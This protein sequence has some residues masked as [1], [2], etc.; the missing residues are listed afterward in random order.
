MGGLS[1]SGGREGGVNI[2]FWQALLNLIFS[3]WHLVHSDII[4]PSSGYVY[5][6][7]LNFRWLN[8]KWY[9]IPY[10][11]TKY[12]QKKRNT[13]Y[14]QCSAGKWEGWEERAM[15]LLIPASRALCSNY[16]TQ[17]CTAPHAST[18]LGLLLC[19]LHWKQALSTICTVPFALTMLCNYARHPVLIFPLLCRKKTVLIFVIL[20]STIELINIYQL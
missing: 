10:H 11:C 3:I 12:Q 18:I 16:A 14:N 19:N 17:L 2:N 1:N 8:D 4:W 7:G 5:I 20:F 13:K 9:Q 6:Q 15:W